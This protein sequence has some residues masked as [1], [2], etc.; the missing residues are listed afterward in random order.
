MKITSHWYWD[1]QRCPV[2]TITEPTAISETF[3]TLGNLQLYWQPQNHQKTQSPF[4]SLNRDLCLQLHFCLVL[5]LP[6]LSHKMMSMGKENSVIL[7]S[8]R[9]ATASLTKHHPM[10]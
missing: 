8:H 1:S 2:S 9:K 4:T 3:P 6:Y 7:S 10:I 5:I